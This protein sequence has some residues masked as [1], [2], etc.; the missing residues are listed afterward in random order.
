[1]YHT[2]DIE[3]RSRLVYEQY[4]LEVYQFMIYFTGNRNN[5]EDL[6]Q[7]VF[8]RVLDALPRYEER[9]SMKT[10]ILSI[11][12]HVAIDYGRKRRIRAWLGMEPIMGLPS[13]H[14]R[15]E[16]E[17]EAKE[18]K[19]LMISAMLRLK[20]KYRSVVILRGLKEFSIKETAEILEC[21][22]AKVRVD[23]HPAV[24]QLRTYLKGYWEGGWEHELSR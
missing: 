14:G 3:G 4:Y 11:A 5:A 2:D 24:K 10:W 6:T 9:S 18:E 20:P 12:K 19:E 7:E 22:E 8:I 13:K 1:M 17:L 23:F 15:P 16:S 21:S